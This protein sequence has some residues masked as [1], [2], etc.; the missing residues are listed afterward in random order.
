M[1]SNFTIVTVP[2][3]AIFAAVSVIIY[4]WVERKKAFGMVGSGLLIILGAF[5]GWA[6]FTGLLVPE[7]LFDTRE[8]YN[9]EELFLPDEMPIEGRM[10]PF[11]WAMVA[12]GIFGF[13]AVLAEGFN[14]KY[15]TGLKIFICLVALGIFFGM[16]GAA[17]M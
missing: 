11:Y 16:I 2:Q 8:A 12:N 3:W 6:I 1:I 15:G 9:G 4:G 17:R 14:K 7:N 5:A 10:L 13:F